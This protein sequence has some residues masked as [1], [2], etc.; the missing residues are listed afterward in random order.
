M[1]VGI[2]A[3]ISLESK[4]CSHS[5]NRCHYNVIKFLSKCVRDDKFDHHFCLLMTFGGD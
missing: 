4:E 2:A 3:G 5:L 1:Q